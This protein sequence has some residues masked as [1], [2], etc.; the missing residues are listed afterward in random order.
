[1]FEKSQFESENN[2]NLQKKLTKEKFS[3][4]PLPGF[5][6]L[7]V[8]PPSELALSEIDVN[9]GY[10]PLIVGDFEIDEIKTK[11]GNKLSGNYFAVSWDEFKRSC[12]PIDPDAPNEAAI[13]KYFFYEQDNKHIKNNIF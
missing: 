9:K 4:P 6:R 13:T 3:G 1:M 11:F 8:Y 7:A 12:L 5:V 2:F 10:H